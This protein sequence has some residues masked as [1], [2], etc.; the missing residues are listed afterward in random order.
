MLE[1]QEWSEQI[2]GNDPL[3]KSFTEFYQRI[4]CYT[5]LKKLLRPPVPFVLLS[6]GP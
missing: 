3:E 5:K 6:V 2:H 1:N 4:A